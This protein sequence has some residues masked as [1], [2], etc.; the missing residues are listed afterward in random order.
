MRNEANAGVPHVRLDA[1]KLASVCHKH[2]IH[3]LAVFGSVLRD[4]FRSD[5]EVD[6]LVEFSPDAIISLLDHVR[7]QDE[8][9]SLF[10]RKVDLVSK[11]GLKG[12]IRDEIL[13]SRQVVY[14]SS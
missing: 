3:E 10:G 4:D 8:F 7:I 1:G 12:L 11:R 2:K 14:V 9:C 6:L 5:S 13:A